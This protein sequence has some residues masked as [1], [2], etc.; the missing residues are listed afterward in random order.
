MFRDEIEIEL[1]AGKGGD[2]LIS[3][4]HEKYVAKGGP[5]G[6]DG[7]RGGSIWI[8]A[9]ADLNS[10]LALG[11]RR[12][13]TARSGQ[14][15]G[16][17]QRTGAGGEDQELFVP[18]GTQVFDSARGHL[19]RD[20]TAEGER[21]E[22]VRGGAGGRGNMHFVS[23][24]HQAPRRA[25]PGQPGEER[26]V[27]L[28][29]KMFAEVGLVGLPNAGKSTFLSRV[30]AATPKIADYPFTTLVPQVGIATVGDH[31]T[32]CI[33][34]LPG[35]IEGA[36]AGHGL[37]DRF[38]KHVE[39]CGVLL[40]LVDVSSA[41]LRDPLEAWEVIEH[42]LAQSSPEL[43][44]KPRLAVATKCEDDEAR[45]R[46]SRLEAGIRTPLV[47]IS[48]V[49]GLGLEELLRSARTLVRTPAQA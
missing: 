40:H 47:R 18:V 49:Q 23:S 34:D 13:Y 20:L 39:R 15:G 14:P 22:I 41:A 6:G 25:T 36:S 7:G 21:V 17:V 32:L 43:A 31:D 44:G 1:C 46:A 38:L 12:R 10:L 4:R 2:G 5:D 26:R 27:R 33:A 48:S 45:E 11:R 9:R 24:V 28:V 19:L 42:E 16:P 29:L 30:T 35:L 37:G 8:V 3:F